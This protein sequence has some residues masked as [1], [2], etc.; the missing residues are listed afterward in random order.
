LASSISVICSTY[1]NNERAVR[2]AAEGRGFHA[3]PRAYGAC[4]PCQPWAVFT[5]GTFEFE[6]PDRDK[7]RRAVLAGR[8]QRQRRL[9][10]A[11]TGAPPDGPLSCPLRPSL[12]QPLP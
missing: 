7:W 6:Y 1:T 11:F 12:Q 5:I 4:L 3:V 8:G 10:G 9:G 2:T